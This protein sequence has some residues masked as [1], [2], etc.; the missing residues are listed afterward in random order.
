LKDRKSD[1]FDRRYIWLA[2]AMSGALQLVFGGSLN[3]QAELLTRD[4]VSAAQFNEKKLAN[5]GCG[6]ITPTLIADA[7]RVLQFDRFTLDQSADACAT[8]IGTSTCGPRRSRCCATS[9]CREQ[10]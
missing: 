9:K 7:I 3:V 6:W 5:T 4:D 1:N 8:A 10:A 2:R